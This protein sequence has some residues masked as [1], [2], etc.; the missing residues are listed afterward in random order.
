MFYT[1]SLSKT[2]RRTLSRPIPRRTVHARGPWWQRI[3]LAT[4]E[5]AERPG[6]KVPYY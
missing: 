2:S 3:W 6:R 5:Q 1:P 4:C